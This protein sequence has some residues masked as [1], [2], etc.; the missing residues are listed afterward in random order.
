MK[1]IE[2]VNRFLLAGL[3]GFLLLAGVSC[4]PPTTSSTPGTAE[5]VIAM[6]SDKFAPKTI[7]INH[8][9][10]ITWVND[11]VAIHTA[12]SD[13]SEGSWNTGDVRPTEARSITFHIPGTYPYHCMYHESMRGTI[14]VK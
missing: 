7:T 1:A 4:N 10:S 14:I 5:T 3:L 2:Q 6:K 11:D 12:T 13:M 9:E 8:G